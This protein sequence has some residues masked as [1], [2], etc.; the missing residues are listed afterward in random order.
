MIKVLYICNILNLMQVKLQKEW[1]F[2]NNNAYFQ[3]NN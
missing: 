3:I 1:D 2:Y